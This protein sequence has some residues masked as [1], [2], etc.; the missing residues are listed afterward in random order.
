MQRAVSVMVLGHKVGV[1]WAGAGQDR[2]IV[3]QC[4]S[5]T[6]PVKIAGVGSAASL[7]RAQLHGWMLLRV[8]PVSAH[9][10]SL[11]SPAS[12]VFGAQHMAT[13]AAGASV[14]CT[15]LGSALLRNGL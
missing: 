3:H 14:H 1:C 13:G 9:D 12:T 8:L 15:K 10:A 7:L 6:L 4:C 5:M 11:A 2:T